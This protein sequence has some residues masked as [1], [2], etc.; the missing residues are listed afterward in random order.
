MEWV[1]ESMN[2]VQFCALFLP[3]YLLHASP[4]IDHITSKVKLGRDLL[5]TPLQGCQ[6]LGM[7]ADSTTRDLGP[8]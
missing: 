5:V 7:E 4:V 6:L 3:H 2:F 1:D 8:P